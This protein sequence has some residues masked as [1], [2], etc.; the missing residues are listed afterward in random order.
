[1]SVAWAQSSPPASFGFRSFTSSH[2]PALQV[3]RRASRAVKRVSHT[4]IGVSASQ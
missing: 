2:D 1:V 3:V 4:P